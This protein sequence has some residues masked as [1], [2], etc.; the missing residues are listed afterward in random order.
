VQVATTSSAREF[1]YDPAVGMRCLI[2]QP[3]CAF[4][5]RPLALDWTHV[6]LHGDIYLGGLTGGDFG[7]GAGTRHYR[8]GGDAVPLSLVFRWDNDLIGI[9]ATLSGQELLTFGVR[10]GP[11]LGVSYSVDRDFQVEGSLDGG[12]LVGYGFATTGTANQWNAVGY[13]GLAVGTRM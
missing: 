6:D 1:T 3:G 10:T 4:Q 11:R 5:M 9:K 2:G 8:I 7:V 13:L 12:L